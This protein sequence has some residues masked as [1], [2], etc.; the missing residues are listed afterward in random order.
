MTK[1]KIV[2]ADD[3][4]DILN[5]LTILFTSRGYEVLGASDG[6]K[7]LQ[8]IEEERPD[9]VILDF[10]MPL[11]DGITVCER[12]RS[13]WPNLFIIIMSGVGSDRLKQQ[14]HTVQAD[15][16]IEK[17]LRMANL[18]ERVKTGLARRAALE[19]SN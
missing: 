18:V 10:M 8:L 2:I 14:S 7:A 4:I 16:Y 3:E 12:A 17:P 15:E 11:M 13:I 19:A 1:P 9:A 6:E 5:L